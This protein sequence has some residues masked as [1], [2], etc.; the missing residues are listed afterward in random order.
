MERL[1]KTVWIGAGLALALMGGMAGAWAAVGF[2]APCE[3]ESSERGRLLCEAIE[4][5]FEA[6]FNPHTFAPSAWLPFER[7]KEV[8]CQMRVGQAD[9]AL[10]EQMAASEHK[11]LALAAKGMLKLIWSEARGEAA[12]GWE[13]K[14][15]IFD[16]AIPGYL[17]EGGCPR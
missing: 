8:W 7:H 15:T 17:L 12:P 16:P 2:D 3:R 9:Q 6:R 14:G 1:K 5:R 11:G 13:A 4:S 10:F